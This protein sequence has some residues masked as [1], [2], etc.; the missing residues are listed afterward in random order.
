MAL[1]SPVHLLVVMAA[2]CPLLG[3][4]EAREAEAL[5]GASAFRSRATDPNMEV[6]F[7]FS[8]FLIQYKSGRVQRF[9]GTTFTPPSLDA[10]TG[11]AS[12]DVVVDQATGL[13]ARIYRPSRGAVIGGGGRRLPVL[14]YFHGGAFVVESAFDPVYHGYLNALVAK[15]NVVAVSVNYRLA[16]EH[17]LP[18]AYDDAWAALQWVVDNA[19]RGG[20]G[21]PWLAK[22]GDV[23]RL[24][25]AGD[26][27]GG[28]IAH[29]LAMRAGQQ[30][31]FRFVPGGGGAAPAIRGVALLDPYFLGRYVFPGA[32]RAW[33]FICAGR[34][35]TGHPYVNPA[36]ALPASAWRALP[37]GRVLMTVS[38]NDRLG[39][40]Q[41][42]Y[43]DA[44]RG[45]GW[46]GEARLYVTPGEGHCYFLNNLAS[47]KAAAH[48]ATLAAF[49]NGS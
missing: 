37:P 49:I 43:V 9:M 12:K 13:R 7:D 41:R 21:E 32:E 30:Q 11:V 19:R 39:P 36:A 47:P 27:A 5:V 46:R 17:P 10:R 34:Y 8:P 6:K 44:L 3:A 38:G 42:A 48:M 45:S 14:L 33:G 18:A 28:N 40:F 4:G 35:G 1:A 26:S 31:S 2:L 22:H 20:G 16:P 25:L 23:S 24:F 15:A 29:N